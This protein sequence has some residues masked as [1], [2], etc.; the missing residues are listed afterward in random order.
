MSRFHRPLTFIGLIGCPHL[1]KQIEYLQKLPIQR[2]SQP[3]AIENSDRCRS[4]EASFITGMTLFV[5]RGISLAFLLMI[6]PN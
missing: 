2:F 3:E 5:D 4:E 1:E 6:L